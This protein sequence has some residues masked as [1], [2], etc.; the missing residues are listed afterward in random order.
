MFTVSTCVFQF[1]QLLPNERLGNLLCHLVQL[2]SKSV[3]LGA[4]MWS[5]RGG[6]ERTNDY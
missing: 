5:F 1:I 4:A 3:E 2:G 6:T